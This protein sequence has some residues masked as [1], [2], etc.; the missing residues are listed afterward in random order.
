MLKF[1]SNA[2]SNE[3]TLEQLSGLAPEQLESLHGGLKEIVSALDQA[4]EDAKV[5][6]RASGVPLDA[7]WLHRV[8]TKKRIVLKFATETHSLL[9]GGTTIAQ[10]TTYDR[11]Y[12]AKFREALVEEFGEEELAD[13]EREVLESARTAYREWI[14]ST[15]QRMW[16]VP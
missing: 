7:N 13:L 5:K 2:L 11:L 10:R 15:G 4:V 6:Q 14:E 9:Q 16:F 8:S 1:F 12:K 3:V